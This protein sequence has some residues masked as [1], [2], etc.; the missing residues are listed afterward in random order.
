M[1]LKK[2]VFAFSIAICLLS[3]GW[4]GCSDDTI[5]TVVSSDQPTT[6]TSSSAVTYYFPLDQGF[7]T[8]YEVTPSNGTTE[9]ETFRVGQEV[10]VYNFDAVE[11]F[12]ANGADTSFFRAVGD[13]LYYYESPRA[14]PERILQLPLEPGQT[15]SRFGTVEAVN[16]DIDIYVDI[17]LGF[18][19]K[20]GENTEGD[21]NSVYKQFPSEGGVAMTVAKVEQLQLDNGR[22]Y[23]HAVKVYN[24]GSA[25]GKMNYYWFVPNVGLVKYVIGAS[26]QDPKGD[27][28]GELISAGK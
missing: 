24:K 13:A 20:L 26:T 23:S 28:V 14:R 12:G 3:V 15:W 16:N 10:P 11:W 22:F 8:S 2:T 7:T 1:L 5:T 4:L 27:L 19:D 25:P 6:S 17:E 18:Y 21:D 9:I